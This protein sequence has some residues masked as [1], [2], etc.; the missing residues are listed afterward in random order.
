LIELL[1]SAR[2]EI[3]PVDG[4][5]DEVTRRVPA[6]RTLT[7]TCLPRHGPVQSVDVAVA[8]AQRGYRA[9]PHL[10]ARSTEGR[11]HLAE[12]VARCEAAGIDEY[13]VIGGDRRE[14]IGPYAWAGALLGD[15][16]E[17]AGA[18]VRVGVAGYPERHPLYEREALLTALRDK[19]ELGATSIVTQMCF[20]PAAILDWVE[21]LDRHGVRLPVWVGVPGVV[22]RARLIEMSGRIGVGGAVRFLRGNRGL[23]RGLLGRR[24]FRPD[25]LIARTFDRGRPASR[26]LSGLHVYSFNQIERTAQWMMGER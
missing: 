10:A 5:V 17:I 4:V 20:D 18:D 26:R 21:D 16:V 8:L 25:D 19:Q 13:F 6:G 1:A 2:M 23:V 9:V 15:L 22:R 14:P 24:E 3:V 11:W 7:V 12:L